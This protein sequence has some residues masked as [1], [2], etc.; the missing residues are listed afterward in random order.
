MSDRW[1]IYVTALVRATTTGFVGVALGLYLVCA[2]QSA[3]TTGGV[4]S[5]G[6]AGAAVAA[7][8]ATLFADRVGRCRF[9]AVTT[10]IGAVGTVAFVSTT[11]LPALVLASFVAMLNGMGRDRGAA[12]ILEQAALPATTDD[13]GRTPRL[14]FPSASAAPDRC[15]AAARSIARRQICQ[16]EPDSPV[17]RVCRRQSTSFGASH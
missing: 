13:A 15:S 8:F 2:G 4:V 16:G 3:A 12:L 7:I 10:F 6:L 1:L 11:A 17:L 9:L 5:A 14:R